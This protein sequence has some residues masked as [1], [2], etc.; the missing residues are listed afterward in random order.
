M[1]FWAKT[2]DDAKPDISVYNHMINVGCVANVPRMRGDEPEY[3]V[4]QV[5]HQLCSPH[6]RG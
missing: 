5:S 1:N 4:E 6:A 3:F 2:T